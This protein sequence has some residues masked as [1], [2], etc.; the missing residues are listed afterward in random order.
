ML[1]KKDVDGDFGYLGIS[2]RPG[3]IIGNDDVL[4]ALIQKV[5]YME[6]KLME[7]DNK[8]NKMNLKIE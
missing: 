8:I 5:K 6:G 2:K 1:T 4:H 7:L 3:N